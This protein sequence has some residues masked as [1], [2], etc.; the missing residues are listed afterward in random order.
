MSSNHVKEKPEPYYTAAWCEVLIP[1][2]Q[3]LNE[4]H[5]GRLGVVKI[6]TLTRSVRRI[7][8]P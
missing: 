4:L 6:Q 7:K 2:K 1:P 5:D 8:K 3:E